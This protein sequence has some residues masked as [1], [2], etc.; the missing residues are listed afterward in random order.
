MR[1]G[2]QRSGSSTKAWPMVNIGTSS[3]N[4]DANLDTHHPGTFLHSPA[5]S[6]DSP[7]CAKQ[8]WAATSNHK[9][10][11]VGVHD[12]ELVKRPPQGESRVS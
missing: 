7:Q 2:D 12:F 10:Y 5:P 6:A 1:D 8:P 3:A 11:D 4:L 9:A